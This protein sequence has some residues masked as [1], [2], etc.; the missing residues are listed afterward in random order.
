MQR[1]ANMLLSWLK[2]SMIPESL[3]KKI[4]WLRS[5]TFVRNVTVL[6]AGSMAGNV[7]QAVGGIIIAR[8]LQP[9]LFGVYAL[10]FSLAGIMSIVLGVGAQDAVT[11]ILGEAYARQDRAKIREALAFLAKMTVSMGGV[12]LLGA[13]VAPVIGFYLYHNAQVG[14]Y[15]AVVICAAIVSTTANSFATIGL[16]VA[17]RITAMSI[18]GLLD[19]LLRT[20]LVVLFVVFGFGVL[21]VVVGHLIG[22]LLVFIVST[23]LWRRLQREHPIFPSIRSIVRQMW[24]APVK[25]YLGF[26]VWIAIDRNISNLYNM[27]PVFLTGIYVVAAQVSYFKLAFGY[28]NLALSFLSPIGVLLNVEFPKMKA[29]RPE[30]LARNFTRVSLYSLGISAALTGGAALVAPLAFHILYGTKF[31]PSIPYIYGLIPFGALMG[32]GIGLGSMF[33]AIQR[34]KIS[35]LINVV[36][37]AIGIP[38]ALY[39]IR[40]FDLWGTVIAVS[41]WYTAAHY[42]GFFYIRSVLKRG[43]VLSA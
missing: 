4:N 15:A 28:M 24:S 14:V 20:L 25:R 12:A 6:Q 31:L 5:H 21:G 32:I 7:L 18:L 9:E 34:V 30:R 22:A 29:S 36:N 8:I 35:I 40:H 23:V 1:G 26:S 42:I 41:I 17:G 33:R 39:L 2:M 16:Q 38:L 3:R 13:L 43:D 19:Q 10:A 11:T 27:L 37:L